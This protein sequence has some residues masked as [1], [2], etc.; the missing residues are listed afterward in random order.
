MPGIPFDTDIQHEKRKYED[1]IATLKAEVEALTSEL[2][3]ARQEYKQK[4]DT[5]QSELS[6][7]HEENTDCLRTVSNVH[8]GT[9]ITGS[10]RCVISRCAC[11]CHHADDVMHVTAVRC[12]C[13][14]ELLRA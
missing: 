12:R 2:N 3:K 4:V 7:V 14:A 8:L 1:K 11:V 6:I 10:C 9:A 13:C 5:L